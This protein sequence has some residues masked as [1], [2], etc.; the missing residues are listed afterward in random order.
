MQLLNNIKAGI[1]AVVFTAIVA[2]I[3][4]AIPIIIFIG[5]IGLCLWVLYH[6]LRDEIN[7]IGE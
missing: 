7:T 6:V 3:I 5:I 4:I 2:A 1:L